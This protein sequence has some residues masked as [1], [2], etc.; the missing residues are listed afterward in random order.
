MPCQGN[1]AVLSNVL[2]WP[3]QFAPQRDYPIHRIPNKSV[4]PYVRMGSPHPSPASECAAPP[5]PRPPE[6][7][8]GRGGGG[9][10]SLAGEGAG[11]A[12][13]IWTT[14]EKAWHSVYSFVRPHSSKGIYSDCWGFRTKPRLHLSQ[15]FRIF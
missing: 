10:D 15:I 3:R 11:R 14:G 7:K 13:S 9:Q 12:K 5:P 1:I 2:N 4:C 6:P 8:G